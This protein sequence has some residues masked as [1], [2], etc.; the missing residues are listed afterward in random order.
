[1]HVTAGAL[2]VR[3]NAEVLLVEHRAYGITLQPGGHVEP[4]DATL[5][6]AAVRELVEETRPRS[7]RCRRLLPMSSSAGSRHGRRSRSR[8]TT[9]S[10]SGMPSR[11]RVR[12]WGAS[13]SL[14]SPELRGIRLP[15][16]SA[17]SATAY[18]HPASAE[19]VAAR[20]EGARTVP[21]TLRGGRSRAVLRFRSVKADEFGTPGRRCR[22]RQDCSAALPARAG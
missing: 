5:I 6:D 8:S 2:L 10:T 7:F 13:R 15:R 11:P 9:T 4:A 18:H 12:M 14:R 1:M 16:R 3:D 21:C 19:G 17:W 20:A 22:C